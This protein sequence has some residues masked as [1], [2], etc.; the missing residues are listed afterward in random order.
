MKLKSF[1]DVLLRW[2]RTSAAW[3][4]GKSGMQRAL[5]SL[6]PMLVLLPHTS[7]VLR[8]VPV[9][10][11]EQHIY[12]RALLGQ[13][14]PPMLDQ[15][16]VIVDVDESSLQ[17]DGRWPWSREKVALLMDELFDRQQVALLGVDILFAEPQQDD[18]SVRAVRQWLRDIGQAD[19]FQTGEMMQGLEQRLNR[20]AILARSLQRESAVL[21]YYY[22]QEQ[23][24][25]RSGQ[26]PQGLHL[27]WPPGQ[28]TQGF[29]EL[30]EMTGYASNLSFLVDAASRGGHINS[31]TDSD[32]MLRSI[33]L[34]VRYEE[35]DSTSYYPSLSLAMFLALLGPEETRLRP[36]DPSLP[37]SQLA[38]LEV[39]QGEVR[40]L[41]PTA[42]NGSFLIPFRS[43]GGRHGGHFQY[44][45]A[46][47]LLAG[48]VAPNTLKGKIVLLGATAPGLRDLRATP[49]SSQFPGVEVHATALAA[50][51]D[52]DFLHVPDYREAYDT[53]AVLLT[54]LVLILVL[55]KMG[56]VGSLFW[57]VGVAGAWM[58]LTQL[59][60]WRL[61]LVLPVVPVLLTVLATYLLHASYGFFLEKRTKRQLVRLFGHYVQSELVE[62]MARQPDAY[63]MQAQL[64]DMTVM[65]C[66]LQHFTNLSEGM[67]PQRV[68]SMLNTI[69]NR[70]AEVIAEHN[71]TIDKY[72]GDCVIVFWGAPVHDPRHARHAVQTALDIGRMLQAFNAELSERDE[73]PIAVNIGIN[74]GS[75]SV[76]DMGSD[77]RRS[78]TVIGDAV[79]LAA[80]LES[81]AKWYGVGTLV[82]QDTVAQCPAHTWRWVDCVRVVGRAQQVELYTPEI[83][84]VHDAR[85][86]AEWAVWQDYTMAYL[87]RDW[88]RAAALLQRSDEQLPPGLQRLHAIHRQRME[89]F[90]EQP[91][92]EDW[93]G[94][95]W[96]HEQMH[97][98][99]AYPSKY[100]LK[101][102][103]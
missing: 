21:G 9:T 32:G 36:V 87:Q 19:R 82:G 18:H 58:L 31:Y 10:R 101:S 62:R 29:A 84:A 5:I 75:M 64:R 35:G 98:S 47:D 66:D 3:L 46:S 88:Q 20:D 93:D 8:Y 89:R 45:S 42:R 11:L 94:A 55:S 52:G 67:D 90:L 79:N 70:M 54:T 33:P 61:G 77:M 100:E 78:Y 24:P 37:D 27:S 71:G 26:L 4:L 13:Q 96:Q 69:F 14:G 91:P 103:I 97:V 53:T 76:G 2:R 15:R 80:R 68:Q 60:F 51:L 6:L 7:G 102:I 25:Q 34:L 48:R 72:I 30:P 28:L 74:S 22:T 59:M 38:G 49:V 12:D 99:L 40:L 73:S 56:A 85:A 16:I 81:L 17:Q 39:R 44:Y 23:P 63:S 86:E 1:A 92:P 50:M 41:L 65:F 43:P 83:S 95:M 57:S